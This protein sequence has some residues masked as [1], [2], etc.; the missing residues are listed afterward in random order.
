MRVVRERLANR[1]LTSFNDPLAL[2]LQLGIRSAP[3]RSLALVRLRGQ[4]PAIDLSLSLNDLKSVL[5][6]LDEVTDAKVLCMCGTF[7]VLEGVL[8]EAVLT[9]MYN[10]LYLYVCFVYRLCTKKIYSFLVGVL[11]C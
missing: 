10:A 5:L 11:L 1:E 9:I 7:L 4:L 2:S 8:C 6:V 3:V